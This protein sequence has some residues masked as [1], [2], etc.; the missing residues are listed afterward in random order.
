MDIAELNFTELSDNPKSVDII[1]P[2]TFKPMGMKFLVVG[3]ESTRKRHFDR[4]VKDEMWERARQA[5]LAGQEIAQLTEHEKDDLEA[6][7]AAAV[8][9]GWEGLSENGLPVSYSEEKSLE[10]M[11]KHPWLQRQIERR[12]KDDALFF[13]GRPDSS[14]NGQDTTSA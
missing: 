13:G 9:V 8:V 1:H 5:F 2:T 6:R 10:L 4:L 12:H 14:L 3:P 11:R 7:A